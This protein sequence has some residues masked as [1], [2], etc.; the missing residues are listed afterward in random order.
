MI[1]SR[2]YLTDYHHFHFPD[3]GTPGIAVSYPGKYYAV[4]PYSLRRLVPFYAENHRMLTLFDSD[5]FG[6]I[7]MVEI[8]A[9]TVGSIQQ[10]Y[11]PGLHVG[12]AAHKGY[13]ELGGSTVVLLFQKG[14]IDLDEDLCDHTRNGIETYVRLGDSIGRASGQLTEPVRP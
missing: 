14:A 9:F 6:Q 3:S 10:R 11:R 1:I 2:L 5:H 4:S 13:F 12:K 7:A 8:G